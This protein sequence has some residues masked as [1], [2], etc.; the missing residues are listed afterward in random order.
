MRATPSLWNSS[1]VRLI[2]D[3]P[4]SAFSEKI[5]ERSLFPLLS[6]PDDRDVLYHSDI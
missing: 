3:G 1:S 4:L 2:D 5:I 6:S